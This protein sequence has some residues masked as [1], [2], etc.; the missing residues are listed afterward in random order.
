M[1]IKYQVKYYFKIKKFE[2]EVRTFWSSKDF[3]FLYLL[4]I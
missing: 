1:G 3:L 2:I 4:L